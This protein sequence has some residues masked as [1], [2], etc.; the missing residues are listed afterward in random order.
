MKDEDLVIDIW[1]CP[2]C[3]EQRIDYLILDKEGEGNEEVDCAT[4]NCHY[5]LPEIDR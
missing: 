1:A 5:T 3:G 2:R 4:C